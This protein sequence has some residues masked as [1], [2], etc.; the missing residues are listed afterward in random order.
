[1]KVSKDKDRKHKR[2]N[3]NV[4]QHKLTVARMSL[5]KDCYPSNIHRIYTYNAVKVQN[6]VRESFPKVFCSAKMV[7]SRTRANS[8]PGK[9]F[10]QPSFVL[11]IAGT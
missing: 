11:D 8:C 6:G 4:Q 10:D 1:M 3:L 7:L 9:N 2:P 5:I